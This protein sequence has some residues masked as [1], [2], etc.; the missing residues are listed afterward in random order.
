[1]NLSGQRVLITGAGSTNGI[2]FTSAKYL[3]GLGARVAIT[4]QSDRVLRRGEELGCP[5][6]TADLTN[7][8]QADQLVAD[9]IK[10]F[11]GLDVLVN[12]AGMTG[13]TDPA[14]GG[15]LTELTDSQWH[16]A[17]ERNLSSAAF[18][19]R[20]ALPHL[21]QSSNGRVIVISS[22]TGP[23]QAMRGEIGYASAKAGLLGFVRAL[24]LDEGAHAITVNAI[25]PGWIATESQTSAEAEQG[26][27]TPLHRSGRPEEIASA[28]A[29]LASPDSGFITGQI[30]IIDGGNSIAEERL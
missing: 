20:A 18:L 6:F 27:R 21:R 16:N 28:V 7:S 10:E 25:A 17:I 9:V 8:S 11:G 13:A 14:E 26:K 1:M 3:Q 30:I 5:A 23:V 19:T 2:G 4:G 15:P 12:N 22:T 29:W 24:A